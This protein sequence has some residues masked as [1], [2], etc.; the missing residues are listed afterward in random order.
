[1]SPFA[2]TYIIAFNNIDIA[3]KEKAQLNFHELIVCILIVKCKWEM[4]PRE[5]MDKSLIAVISKK[6]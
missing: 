5:E 2:R 4:N 1:M 6:R 3:G